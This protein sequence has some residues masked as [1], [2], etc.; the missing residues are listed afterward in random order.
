MALKTKL[1]IAGIILISYGLN[2][3]ELPLKGNYQLDNFRLYYADTGL[4][5]AS[6]DDEV[7]NDLRINKNLGVYKGAIYENIIA[8]ALAKQGLPLYFYKRSDGTL[9]EE[10]FLRSA[11]HL[12]PLEAKSGNSKAKS[13]RTL[14]DSNKYPDISFG[15]KMADA[16]IG[17]SNGITTFPFFL[18]FLL[19]DYLSSLN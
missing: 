3:P 17:E 9:E 14:V 12:I 11:S 8:V 6:L 15:I 10:F 7:Q 4:L 2:F 19:K 16:N 13:L 5:I 18:S 1:S